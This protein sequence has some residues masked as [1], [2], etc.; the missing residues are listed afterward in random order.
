MIKLVIFDFDGVIAQTETLNMRVFMKQLDEAGVSYTHDDISNFMGVSHLDFRNVMDATFG[1]QE[2]YRNWDKI[3]GPWFKY[4]PEDPHELLTE[5]IEELLI[6][7]KNKN[8]PCSIA[9]NAVPVI[10]RDILEKTNL[11]HYFDKFYSGTETGHI[12][13]DPF[14]FEEAIRDHNVLP[15]EAIVIE[16]S[17]LGI[18]AGKAAGAFTIALRDVDGF[19]RQQEAD[20][21]I[22]SILEVEKYVQNFNWM[23]QKSSGLPF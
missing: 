17:P 18:R 1:N 23:S 15:E 9:T 16:D 8:I 14:V 4:Y 20:V 13:P 7:L 5:N 3:H 21:I 22:T 11:M 2:A 10:G 12:K 19:A 6:Y